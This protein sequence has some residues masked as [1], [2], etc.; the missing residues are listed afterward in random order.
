MNER[1]LEII[2]VS[3]GFEPILCPL[4]TKT[5][6]AVTGLVDIECDDATLADIL[7]QFRKTTGLVRTCW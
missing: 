1:S 7:R 5:M 2:S 3:V 4:H 6:S